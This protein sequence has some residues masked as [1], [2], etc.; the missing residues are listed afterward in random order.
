[1]D[2]ES[3]AG[4]AATDLVANGKFGR[5]ARLQSGKIESV[6][7]DEAP[8]KMMS[9]DSSIEIVHAATS[10]VATSGDGA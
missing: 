10:V 5:M 4:S 1:M 2:G 6:T 7:I 8:E 9:I 3:A